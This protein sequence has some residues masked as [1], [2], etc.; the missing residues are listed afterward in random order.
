[1]PGRNE[2]DSPRNQLVPGE[3]I[4][5]EIRFAVRVGQNAE[6][7]VDRQRLRPLLPDRISAFGE[8]S[9]R[10]RQPVAELKNIVPVPQ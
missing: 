8:M 7:P 1:M 3:F 4:P 5:N 10:Q 9:H 6:H 2:T